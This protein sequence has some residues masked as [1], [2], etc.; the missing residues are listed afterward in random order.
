MVQR[1]KVYICCK[2]GH[3]SKAGRLPHAGRADSEYRKKGDSPRP[4]Y[5]KYFGEHEVVLGVRLWRT[6]AVKRK[7][8]TKFKEYARV[9]EMKRYSSFNQ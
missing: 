7:Y 1:R 5:L 2:C 9:R 3:V 8:L 4:P 6:L